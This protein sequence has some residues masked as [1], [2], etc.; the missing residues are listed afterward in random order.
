MLPNKSA[1]AALVLACWGSAAFADIACAPDRVIFET[2]GGPVPIAVEVADDDAERARGLMYR[3]TLSE[4][5]G[6]LF[7][8]DDPR[9]V[10]FWMRNTYIPLDLVFLDQG[11]VIRH[12]RRNAVPLDETPIPGAAAG[13]PEPERQMVLEIGGGEADRLGLAVGQ[14]MA[15]PRLAQDLAALPCR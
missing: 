4:G 12:I 14:P 15:H 7:I 2:P 8:Y 9:T 10:S 11:G 5:T 1:L 13:D 6:M 3:R